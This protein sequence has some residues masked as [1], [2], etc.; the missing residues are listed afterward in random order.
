MYLK[1]LEL[2]G[3]KTFADRT[4]LEFTPGITAIVGPNGSGK[5]NVFDAIR[6][7]LGEVGYKSLRSGRMDDVIF[8]GS[9]SR[10][11][12][13]MG[14][15]QLTI[16]NDSGALPV[17][18][19]EVTVTRRANRGG[20]GEYLLNMAPCRLRDIQML[21]LGTGLGGRS[22][23][24]IG[25]GQVDSILNAGPDER[26]ALLEEAAGLA[27]YKRRR[28]EAER[29]LANAGANLLRVA[30]VLAELTTQMEALREQAEAA[31]AY[32]AYTREIHDLE[33][34]LQ[35]DDARRIV[36]Q[37]R[38]IAAQT[39]AVQEQLHTLAAS[40]AE[41]G[42]QIDQGRSRAAEVARLWEE[43]QRTLLQLVEDLSARESEAQVLAERVRGA[44]AQRARLAADAHRLEADLAEVDESLDVLRAQAEQLRARRD[45]LLERLR[46]TEEVQ[47]DT[48]ASQRD[49]EERLAAARAEIADLGAARTRTAHELTRLDER[50][51]ALDEQIG[52]LR[53]KHGALASAEAQLGDT[54]DRLARSLAELTTRRGEAGAVAS[55]A[56]ARRRALDDRLTASEESLRQAAADRQVVTQTLAFLEDMSAR[57]EGYEKGVREILLAKQEHPEQFAGIRYPVVELLRVAAPHRPAIEAALGRRLFSLVAGTVDDVKGGLRYLRGNGQ[58]SA[59]FIPIDLLTPPAEDSLPQDA[60]IVGRAVDLVELTN[61]AKDVVQALLGDVVIVATLDAAVGL[62]ASGYGGRIATLDGELL[63]PDGVITFR[64]KPDGESLLLGRREQ[65]ATLRE[66][67]AGLDG[68]IAESEAERWQTAAELA[69][70]VQQSDAAT[71]EVRRL[72]VALRE[73][74]AA[75]APARLDA[76]RLPAERAEVEGTLAQLAA[77]QERLGTDTLRLEADEVELGRVIAD[78]ELTLGDAEE[79]LRTAGERTRA[80]G[81]D[82]ADVRVQLAELAGMLA[83]LQTRVEEHARESREIGGRRD[84]LRGE[85]AVLDGERHLLTVSLEQAQRSREELVSQQDDTRARLSAFD[86]ERGTLQQRLL[87]L[88]G[89][90][91]EVQDA[92]HDVEEQAHRLEVRQAQA[93]AEFTAAVRRISEEFGTG[94]DDVRELRLPSGRDE[95]QGRIQALRGLV[96][97]L[98]P[99]NLRAVE[100]HQT[101]AL[102]VESLRTQSDDLTRARVA[103]AALIQRLDEVLRVRF[104]ETFER[105][106][107]EFNRLFVRLF[108]GGRARLLLVD[109]EPGT[110][111]GIEIEAQL[112]GKKMRS[113]SALSGGER[114][115]VA[116]SLIFAMLRVHPSPFCIFDEVEAA[117]DDANTKKFT[118]LLRELAERTQV[119][120]ITHNKGTME[121]S[122]VLYGVTMELPGVS[123]IISMRLTRKGTPE[124]VPAVVT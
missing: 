33:L 54:T 113:L 65:I 91:R 10:R 62:R 50:R 99:V 68:A 31:S 102:R 86:E 34:A 37:L 92:L 6:W 71:A 38:R 52:A 117:L 104:A 84:T 75:L 35:V 103:M 47:E 21:F 53:A 45:E 4:E 106:D 119:L 8:A 43:A 16:N 95:A 97:A 121:A 1:H 19:A 124:P 18:Y 66:R 17:D 12:M 70:A 55:A 56:D 98:G 60:E 114:V 48:L 44:E 78:R 14:A 120:I 96:A 5:S 42:T 72:E 51:A 22:Y 24:L 46:V 88:E 94:W 118:T 85:L 20:E 83:A 58:G 32:Q 59:S 49:A 73:L 76:A 79:A 101:V 100:E 23:S 107:E 30:D 29:R 82:L 109:G 3:F 2:H 115:L 61:G 112:P 13:G 27:R 41:T 90:W 11:T 57:L 26:R 15:V 122:D 74:E 69:G 87:G 81:D 63:S 40:A 93:D 7:A 105:V 123:K 77:E 64:G 9:E 67:R 80:A 36:G 25:Q 116:L 111:P 108:A 39:E 110:E 89:R 28:R